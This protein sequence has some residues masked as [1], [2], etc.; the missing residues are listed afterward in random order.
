MIR[1][2]DEIVTF[3]EPRQ[4]TESVWWTAMTDPES[5]LPPLRKHLLGSFDQALEEL[6]G[7]VLMMSAL[8]LRSLRN[9][10]AGLEQHDEDICNY[11]I[12]D[13]EEVDVLE[14]Q[15]DQ[16]AM[17]SILQFQPVAVD[18]R[19]A[20]TGAKIGGHLEKL[21]DVAVGIA[22]RARKLAR[23]D[24]LAETALLEPLAR[25]ALGMVEDALKAYEQGRVDLGTGLQE[26]RRLLKQTAKAISDEL[27]ESMTGS[28]HR[29]EQI[30][31]LVFI[32]RYLEEAATLARAIGE[33]C[34]FLSEARDIRHPKARRAMEG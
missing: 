21:A 9:A 13:D 20:L 6:R 8:S 25:E 17:K 18:L 29:V 11:V 4:G 3:R 12:A 15:V 7:C 22:K 2:G 30:L 10:I 27:A 14:Q 28:P 31:N 5:P 32:A 33:D 16:L 1:A 19:A 24:P 26:R 23:V 34:V